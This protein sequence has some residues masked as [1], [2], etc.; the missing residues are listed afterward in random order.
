M[1]DWLK[2]SFAS[3]QEVHLGD[4][5]FRLCLSFVL[6]AAVAVIYWATHRRDETFTRSFLSTLVLLAILI[7]MV[8]QVI[9][10]S[11]ARAFSLVGALS[12][13]RFRTVV[14]DTRDTAFVIFAVVVGMAVG[15]G[16]AEVALVGLVVVGA[17][18]AA[19][20]SRVRTRNGVATPFW[21]LT[22][23]LGLGHP[24][25]ELL[26]PL[27]AEHCTESHL[28]TAATGRQGAALDV[29]YKVRLRPECK[30]TAFVAALNR[31][32]GVQSVDL[33]GM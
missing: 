24:P 8:T 12:I 2:D 4:L 21:N 16:H 19:T 30:P 5:I 32:E 18:A 33:R 14:E 22:A 9:G 31:V 27:L 28:L 15:A 11:V 29:S 1:P 6:G 25:E 7:A 17:A 26:G 13:V 20:M 23:R 10:D 3:G